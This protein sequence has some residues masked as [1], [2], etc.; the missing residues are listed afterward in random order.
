MVT[1]GYIN[2]DPLTD[3]APFLDAMHIDLK[4][5]DEGIYRNLSS[6]KLKP[7]LDTILLA[8][9]KGIW[10]E[11]INLVVPQWTDNMDMIRKMCGWIRDRAGADTPLHLSRF[12]PL[13]KLDQLY[14]TPES[15]LVTAQK[16]AFEEKLKYVYVDNVPDFD[17]N[18]YCSKCKTLL[19]ERR[20][21]I[22]TVKELKG[23]KCGKCGTVIPGV[24]EG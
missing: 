14:P 17:S 8:K 20:G 1:S 18:T 5:F 9:E 4:S 23:S 24:W 6:G 19:V 2:P 22:V 10:F 7:V 13:Y 16:I 11:I 21:Y 15:T 12:F 3:L